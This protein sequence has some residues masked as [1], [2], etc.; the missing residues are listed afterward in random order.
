V[1]TTMKVLIGVL[2]AVAVV[3]AGV[4]VVVLLNGC[5]GEKVAADPL[6]GTQ[7]QVGA[8]DKAG[9]M[10]SPV[11]GTQLTAEFAEG[12]VRGTAGCNS[13]AAAYTVDGDSLSIAQPVAT[14]MACEQPIMD[15]ETA[16]LSALASAKSFKQDTNRLQLFNEAGLLVL[17]FVPYTAAPVETPSPA[18]VDTSW[19]RIQAAGKMIVG[20]SADYPP[21]ESRVGENQI[22]GFD[23]ALMDE[24]GRRLGVSI[25]YHDL[26]FDALGPALLG[27]QMDAAIAAISKTPER[28]AYA[29]FSSVYLVD[30]GAALA[31]QAADITLTKLED[32]AKYK[33]GVQ[34]NSVYKNKIQ[35]EFID[36]GLMPADNLFAYE[37]AEDAVHDLVQARIELV[38]MDSQAAQ[39][40]AGTEGVKLV[41]IGGAEQDY[42][43][44]LPKGAAALKAKID[45]AI[46]ALF[47]DGTIS[48]LSERYLGSPQVLP[49]PTPGPTSAPVA[50]PT[51]VDNMALVQHLSKEGDMKPGQAFT[52]AWQVKNSGTCTWTTGYR[53]VFASG[54]K[55]AGEP[56]A[57]AREVKPGETYDWQV[58]LVAPQKAGTY[59][60]FWQQVDAQGRGVGEFL[61]VSIRVV[62]GP[63]PTPKPTQTP[64]PGVEFNVD[65]DHIK[66]GESVVLSWK[67]TNVK[68]YYYYDQFENWKD[69]PMTGDQGSSK[70]WP[71]VPS[72]TYYLKVFFKDNTERTLEK[73]VFV[74]AAPAPVTIER[75]TIDPPGQ[76]TLG[77]TVT[78]RWLVEGDVDTVIVSA[79]G[80]ELS[81][82]TEGTVN[83]TPAEAGTVTYRIEARAKDGSVQSKEEI[84]SV[85]PPVD[86]VTPEPPPPDP[87]IYTFDVSPNQV[88]V[89]DCVNVTYSAGGGTASLRIMRD[90]GPYLDPPDL[91]G[92]FCDTLNEARNYTYQLVARGQ[93]KDVPSEEK[94]V[95]AKEAPPQDPLAGTHWVVTSIQDGAVPIVP[96]AP[97][98]A[99]FGAGGMINGTGACM[100]YGG[101]YRAEGDTI[102]ISGIQSA[103]LNCSEFPDIEARTAQDA[104]FLELLPMATNFQL[105]GERLLFLDPGGMRLMELSLVVW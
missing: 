22:D 70:E 86:P 56:V 101:N 73:T 44:A 80:Q 10:T 29:D 32:I 55:M 82:A 3:G 35:T 99:S 72:T 94:T 74:E 14:M 51:C 84:K 20:T 87:V 89:G 8:Y 26:P 60:G 90:G 64:V 33:V 16:F 77:Q 17:D 24:I 58:N 4:I 12:Q 69:H 28:E 78:I 71:V 98:T 31:Q 42:A 41:G 91:E 27:G 37:K 36:K 11:A 48:A 66:A 19:D 59:E 1:S 13:Y 103:A 21:F 97:P 85:V 30:K 39:A 7:W 25:E 2:V 79:N 50:T 23:I 95:S 88:K 57:M 43:I 52:V 54:E 61:K 93:A 6:A 5:G 18:A 46:S 83:H 34:R 45:D 100:N 102:S 75:W 96:E 68:A 47:G 67:V 9:G 76:I 65:R 53:L 63:T 104:K 15:Q 92:S 105:D 38:I 62:S 81:R 49:T 40:F